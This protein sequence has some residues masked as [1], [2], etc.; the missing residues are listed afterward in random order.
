MNSDGAVAAVDPREKWRNV[1]LLAAGVLLAMGL[2][3]SASAVVPQLTA[4]WGL[5]GAGRAWLTMSVQLGFVAGTMASALANLADRVEIRR[6]IAAS[7]FAGALLNAAIAVADPG[8]AGALVL[9]FLTGATL[10][11]V[12]PPGMKLVAT[13]CKRDRGLGIGLLVGALTFGSAIPHLLNALPL[14]GSGGMP[15]WRPV[16][17]AASALA[18]AGAAVVAG[19]VRP[20][21]YLGG[22]APFRWR[23]ALEALADRPS[24]LANFGYLG[25][26]WELYAMW[27]WVPLLL[28]ASY[29]AA[30]RSL[31]AARLAGFGVIAAGALGSIVAGVLADRL[32][33]TTTAIAALAV[34]G[35][36]SLT[37]GLAY[38]APGL[39]TALCLLWGFAVVADSAQFSAAVSELTD[40]RY[41]GTALTVQTCLGFVLSVATIQLVPPLVA[42]IGWT[43]VFAVLAPGP[44]FGIVSMARLRRLPAA[45]RMASG[46]R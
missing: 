16:V 19:F 2:W 13:W 46:H 29:G 15:P 30:G 35:L 36:C 44:L 23:F 43:W 20:G 12:Y 37:A 18:A 21:P 41:V 33:R 31:A 5:S 40:P 7:A 11:G 25:H 32:G 8:P 4:E 27:T 39:L 24:R 6:L 14:F 34:S 17:L 38:G 28:L 26:M 9:R 45:L 22:A 3:F 42:R 10:A 1:A